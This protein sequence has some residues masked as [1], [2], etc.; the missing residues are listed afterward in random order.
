MSPS[1][2]RSGPCGAFDSAEIPDH[3]IHDSSLP[4]AVS[5]LEDGELRLLLVALLSEWR[6]RTARGF[7]A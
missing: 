6:I 1:H 2:K 5:S 3:Y 4:S 7:H